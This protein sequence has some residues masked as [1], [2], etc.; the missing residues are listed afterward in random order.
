MVGRGWL[1]EDH[2]VVH[3]TAAGEGPIVFLCHLFW[4][5]IDSYWVVAVSLY[6]LQVFSH[7]LPSHYQPNLSEKKSRLVQR[8]QWLA[9]KMH[10][11]DKLHF[12]EVSK[13]YIKHGFKGS[14]HFMSGSLKTP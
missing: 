8:I 10:A 6:S 11:E 4:P 7:V 3:I 13:D 14:R 12:Y 2:G 5:F 1:S 9:D